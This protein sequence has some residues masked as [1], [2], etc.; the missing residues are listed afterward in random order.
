HDR[1]IS[2][3]KISPDGTKLASCSADS[4]ISIISL[5]SGKP[6]ANLTGHLAGVNTITW[7][8]DSRILAS[9]SDDKSIRIWDTETAKPASSP[10][11]GHHNYVSAICISPK[12]NILA[13]GSY[14]EAL[15]IWDVRLG[16]LL[17]SLPAH[18]DPV[19][20][21][22]FV[23]DATLVVS[24]SSDG[25]VR[26]WDTVTGQC[27]RTIVHEPDNPAVARVRFAPNG[28]FLLSVTLDNALRLWNYVEGRCVKTFLGHTNTKYGVGAGFA[29]ITCAEDKA[30]GDASS[31]AGSEYS[32]PTKW[33]CVVAGS[34]NGSI[35][36]WDVNSKSILMEVERA[37]KG[38]VLALDVRDN[39][40]V[41][42]SLDGVIKIWTL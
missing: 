41:T 33:A 37:H 18:S 17:R 35:F 15:F 4:T 31:L 36:A 28:N 39:F 8:P 16:R 23:R 19:T 21:V 34:E 6:L 42:A 7:S 3:V 5:P 22:D 11:M 10:L 38:P 20:C 24:C 9:G 30:D 2:E 12:G 32:T 26:V 14:D 13:S 1:G 25:L 29:T 27:L 40:V